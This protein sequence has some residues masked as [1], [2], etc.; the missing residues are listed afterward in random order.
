MTKRQQVMRGL[1]RRRYKAIEKRAKRNAISSGGTV[2]P[3]GMTVR[4][5]VELCGRGHPISP[6]VCRVPIKELWRYREFSWDPKKSFEPQGPNYGTWKTLKAWMQSNGWSNS[7]PLHFSINPQ[8]GVAKVADGNHRLVMGRRLKMKSAPVSFVCR[9]TPSVYEM[10]RPDWGKTIKQPNPSEETIK[11]SVAAQKR[12]N[13]RMIEGAYAK[14]FHKNVRAAKKQIN[15]MLHSKEY[16]HFVRRTGNDPCGAQLKRAPREVK[17]LLKHVPK[18][19]TGA[20][21]LWDTKIRNTYIAV[22]QCAKDFIFRER[23]YLRAHGHVLP[24]LQ[25]G[26]R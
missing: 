24:R 13:W 17:R 4:K 6:R 11:R 16:K 2:D 19:Q 3:C 9:A 15:Q 26:T 18:H 14:Y 21:E 8:S 25:Q 23:V 7:N 12:R 22:M 20:W 10:L 1:S 5:V